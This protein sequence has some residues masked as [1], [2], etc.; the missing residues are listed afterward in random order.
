LAIMEV[1]HHP[2]L[3]DTIYKLEIFHQILPALYHPKTKI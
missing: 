3:K 2:K 1:K